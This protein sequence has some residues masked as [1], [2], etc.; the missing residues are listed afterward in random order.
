LDPAIPGK[1]RDD[2]LNLMR[3][4]HRGPKAARGKTGR[5][6]RPSPSTAERASKCGQIADRPLDDAR[7]RRLVDDYWASS[8][9]HNYDKSWRSRLKLIV[10]VINSGEHRL[11]RAI[12]EIVRRLERAKNIGF[13]PVDHVAF[14]TRVSLPPRPA[15]ALHRTAVV[16]KVIDLCSPDTQSIIELGSGWGEHLCNLWLQGAPIDAR[17]YACEL[18]ESGR[19]CALVLAALEEQ[20]QLEAVYFNYVQP[21]FASIPKNQKEVVVYSVHSVEQVGEVPLDL[22][23]RLCE[24][25][26]VVKGAHFE[27]IGWQMIE[28][29]QKNEL[30]L[31]HQQR[32]TAQGYNKNFWP[33]LKQAEAEG[34][35]T[36]EAAVPNF[37]G[38]DYNPASL[39]LWRKRPS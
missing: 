19:K 34:L 27:P 15:G 14:N 2:V 36:I 39:I 6:S 3:L 35:I 1:G 31:Q 26:Q 38:R 13:D 37:F 7:L 24:L 25:G 8:G 18:T 20:L 21:E 22:I 12:P 32:C 9:A 16:E 23:R 17:Y 4:F 10:E 29:S 11:S 5:H 28:D 30:T 33:M